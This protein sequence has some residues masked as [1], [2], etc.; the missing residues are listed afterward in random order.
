MRSL[1]KYFALSFAIIALSFVGVSA[2]S[3]APASSK[4]TKTVE[5]Q[6]SKKLLSLPRYGVFDHITYQVSGST[7]T[8]G[9]KVITLGTKDM[10][11]RV[12]KDI[13][14]I[15]NVINNIEELP[16]GGFD[17]RIRRQAY[18]TF[19]NRGPAQY[20]ATINPDVRIIVERGHITLEGYVVHQSDSNTLNILANGVSGV[21]S[22][23]NN[24]IV[25][26]DSS[27]Q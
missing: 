24:L 22:V 15:T 1:K 12:V 21:F 11:A 2:K 25:G 14:G 19:V 9:G 17:E 7:V 4:P 5:Q 27:R 26:R 20:F 13:P 16:V 8:L 10:A 3:V 23:K 18:A 6:I